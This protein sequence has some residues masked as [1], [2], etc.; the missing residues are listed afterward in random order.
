MHRRPHLALLVAESRWEAGALGVS[1]ARRMRDWRT[2]RTVRMLRS[3]I[4]LG[5]G[6]C[7]I[8]QF[9]QDGEE[10]GSR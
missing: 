2:R 9:K 10:E 5:Y 7:T 3:S 4:R 6:R 8:Q 1:L